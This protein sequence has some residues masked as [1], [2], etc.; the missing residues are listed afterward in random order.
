MQEQTILLKSR[1]AFSTTFSL[2][3]FTFQGENCVHI[4]TPE[5]SNGISFAIKKS[6]ISHHVFH[7]T[8]IYFLLKK[9]LYLTIFF[10]CREVE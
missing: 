6:L 1:F 2:Y 10:T 9:V 3:F 4:D 7:T 8:M 5:H